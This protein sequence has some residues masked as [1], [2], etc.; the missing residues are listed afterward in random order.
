MILPC[1]PGGVGALIKG[2]KAA[3]KVNDASKTIKALD[4]LPLQNHHFATNKN[5]T[6]TPLMSKISEKYGLKLTGEWNKELLPHQGR[7]PNDY[8]DFVLDKLIEIDK[9]SNGDTEKFLEFFEKEVK[10]TIRNNPELLKKSGW[11]E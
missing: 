5:K 10:E 6:Y 3:D 2:V 11:V 4:S 9:K 8:H 1:V 7:H